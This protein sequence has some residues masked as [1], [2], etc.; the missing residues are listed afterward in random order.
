MKLKKFGVVLGLAV[1][2]VLAGCQNADVVTEGDHDAGDVQEEHTD[3]DSD[4]DS[5]HDEDVDFSK[6]FKSSKEALD[7]YMTEIIHKDYDKA[8]EA[9]HQIDHETFSLED[10]VAYQ[11]SMQ[12]AKDVHGY[13]IHDEQTFWDFEFS[14]T[15][16]E[17]VDFFDVD[18]ASVEKGADP[19]PDNGDDDHN[20]DTGS[21][22]HDHDHGHNMTTIGIAAVKRNGDWFILQGLSE[23]ELRDLTRKYTNQSV[24]LN[25][26]E[27]ESYALGEIA[28]VGNMMISV[29]EVVKDT[30]SN[31]FKL[32][33]A[34]M[35]VGFDP[36]D[37]DYFVSKFAVV[38]SSLKNYMSQPVDQ[39][40]AFNGLVR[41][42]SYARGIL[43]IPVTEGFE[44]DAVYFLMNT[45]DPEKQPIKFDLGR[46]AEFEM[47]AVYNTLTR[48][49]S[50][51]VNEKAYIDG[52]MLSVTDVSFKDVSSSEST[53]IDNDWE[54]MAVSVEISNLTDEQVYMNQLYLTARSS[55][56]VS[57]NVHDQFK[58]EKMEGVM[59][60]NE[61]LEF[62][63]KKDEKPVELT[64]CIRDTRPNNS[65]TI[66][67]D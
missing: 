35:N 12:L 56:G 24:S 55:D 21:D 6:G 28:P 60:I 1:A 18:I 13:D 65:M 58:T 31:V 15:K 41:A 5:N 19:L 46:N 43:H 34:I 42:G 14:G 23:Y 39:A 54:V 30:E 61:D 17:Q 44:T 57:V 45:V 25:M 62:L 50:S 36:L 9:L 49:P 53:S 59:T 22:Y 67:I 2:L 20:H 26:E 8:Y 7:V 63:V 64:L 16:F 40:G 48:K 66:L 37:T 38:D 11:S 27:K 29:N 47:Q 33:V 3:Q 4:Q 32:D 10:F 51:S 52:L